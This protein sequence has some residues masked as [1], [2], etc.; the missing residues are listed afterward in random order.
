MTIEK[1]KDIKIIAWKDFS[2]ELKIINSTL[3]F[4]IPVKTC[5]PGILLF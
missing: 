1:M 2:N 3:S 4:G 5:K